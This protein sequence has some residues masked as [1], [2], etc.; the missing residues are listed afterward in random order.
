[1]LMQ[2]QYVTYHHV[3][4]S[5]FPWTFIKPQQ[6]SYHFY[7][8]WTVLLSAVFVFFKLISVFCFI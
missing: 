7:I 3:K 8:N 2:Q 1:M 4:K 6:I 5:I